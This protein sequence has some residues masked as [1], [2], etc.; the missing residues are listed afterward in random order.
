MRAIRVKKSEWWSI[1]GICLALNFYVSLLSIFIA[2]AHIVYVFFREKLRINRT[3][4][5]LVLANL[6]A[7]FLF[8][9]W[10]QIISHNSALLQDKTDWTNTTKS[11]IELWSFWE[12]HLNSLFIDLHPRLS[13]LLSPRLTPV[14]VL[15]ISYSF[16]FI[17]RYYNRKIWLF[18]LTI[19]IVPITGLILPDLISGS[20]RSIMTRYFFPSFVGIEI[21]IAFWLVEARS[22]QNKLRWLVFYLLIISGL[23]SAIISSQ[24]LTWWNKLVGYDNPTIAAIINQYDRP[25]L[26]SNDRDINLGNL[27]S[28]SYLLDP[29]VKLLLVERNVIPKIPKGNFSEILVWNLGEESL[30]QFQKQNNCQLKIIKGSYYPSLYV[31]Q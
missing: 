9:P 19:T 21:A 10:L 30:P 4:F 18:L 20:Q 31:I 13:L 11:F 2:V 17:Y 14:F 26:I 24:S 15:L 28:L 8:A 5:S 7:F 16:Y 23:A 12:L 22:I 25:L 6:G 27:I 3:T 29:Q 1:Y